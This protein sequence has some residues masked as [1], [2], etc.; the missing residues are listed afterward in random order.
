MRA[1]GILWHFGV[2]SALIVACTSTFAALAWAND[3]ALLQ[4]VL[5]ADAA[6]D[7]HYARQ[8]GPAAAR[9][10]GAEAM[11]EHVP[12]SPKRDALRQ[13][14]RYNLAC[15]LALSGESEAAVAV[16]ATA[17]AAGFVDRAHIEGDRDL[18]SLRKLPRF[19]ALMRSLARMAEL[20]AEVAQQRRHLTAAG[21][22]AGE[23]Q[24]SFDFDIDLIAGGHLKLADLRGKVV[25]VDLW[26]T[27]CAPCLIGLPRLQDLAKRRAPKVAVV[28]LA[29][30][31]GMSATEATGR[32]RDV[33]KV[34]GATYPNG[35]IHAA[36][37]ERVGA[38]GLPTLLL[39]D[40]TGRIRWRHGGLPDDEVLEALID[41]LLAEDAVPSA[42]GKP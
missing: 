24:R 15:A 21:M 27:W 5:Q 3:D 9:L 30:E 29:F 14:V 20:Q 23:A 11:L 7:L 34:A 2:A 13:E 18:E 6:V 31:R 4:A 1:S 39:V 10:R 42:G 38:E 28:G 25:V 26:G 36:V 35:L 17:V 22:L 37:L 33:L 40:Q 8:Y 19:G 16:L 41:H 32:V 12:E